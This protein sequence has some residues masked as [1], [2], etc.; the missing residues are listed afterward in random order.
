MDCNLPGSSV[1]GI[2]EMEKEMATHSSILAWIKKLKKK[3]KKIVSK[4]K[5]VFIDKRL[6][7]DH[8]SYVNT[9]YNPPPPTNPAHHKWNF[10]LRTA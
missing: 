10:F 2:L 3:K 6:L 7:R 4:N 9:S 1:R 8:G 5:S